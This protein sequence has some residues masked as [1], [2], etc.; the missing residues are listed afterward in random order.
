MAET[1]MVTRKGRLSKTQAAFANISLWRLVIIK[2]KEMSNE[3]SFPGQIN[4]RPVSE[5]IKLII[6]LT[7]LRDF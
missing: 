3:K 6:R 4:S 7:S 1:D 5:I 2:K